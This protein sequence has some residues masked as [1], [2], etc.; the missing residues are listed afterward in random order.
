MA[1]VTVDN[2]G[3]EYIHQAEPELLNGLWVTY[4]L[5]GDDWERNFGIELP[6]GTVEKLLGYKLTVNDGAVS[7]LNFA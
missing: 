7:S 5:L 3:D 4:T 2:Y 1:Y 6:H